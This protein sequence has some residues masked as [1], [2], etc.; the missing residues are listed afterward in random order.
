MN[1]RKHTFNRRIFYFL[2][3]FTGFSLAIFLTGENV[4]A[5]QSN[6]TAPQPGIEMV[7]IIEQSLTAIS[8]FFSTIGGIFVYWVGQSWKQRQYIESKV[9]DFECSLD[10]TNVKKMISAELQCIELFPFMDSA[11]ERFVIVNDKLWTEALLECKC[12]EILERNYGY[13]ERGKSL[14]DQKK[15]VLETITKSRIRDEFSSF[16]NHLQHFEK[17]IQAKALC[18]KKLKSYLFPWFEYIKIVNNSLD[19]PCPSAQRSYTPQ[20]ALL[21]YMG[22]LEDIPEESLSVVQKDVRNLFER[23]RPLSS[24][25]NKK[26][27]ITQAATVPTQV[28]LPKSV[29]AS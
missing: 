7:G 24:F 21:E 19:V 29:D 1:L 10:T 16:L 18:K 25:K 11:M 4:F 13:I 27:K 8:I 23:Y 9:K 17:M 6:P 22:I 12:N 15:D 14:Y 5:Q 20:E 26:T 2:F 3:I 28:S